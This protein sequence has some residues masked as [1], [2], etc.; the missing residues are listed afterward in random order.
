MRSARRRSPRG[1]GCSRSAARS[2]T[3]CGSAVSSASGPASCSATRVNPDRVEGQK[4]VV[5]ELV[6]QLGRVPDVIALPFGG[7]GNVSAVA[8]G[9]DDAGA[10]RAHRRRR[11]GRARDHV[12]L[13]DPH[14]RAR[15]CRER[16]PPRRERAR[17]GRDALRGRDPRRVATGSRR[18]RAPSASPRPQPGSVRSSGSAR[19]PARRSRASSP[20]MG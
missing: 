12:G 8:A 5:S 2:T 19:E 14:Q 7:G 9:L 15:A 1:R 18:P 16:H 3:R 10:R 11:G 4:S 13:R 20:G 17:R 6:E